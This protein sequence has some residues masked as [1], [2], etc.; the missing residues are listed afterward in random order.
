MDFSFDVVLMSKNI[1]NVHIFVDLN[2]N[3]IV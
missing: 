3:D 2:I 1:Y